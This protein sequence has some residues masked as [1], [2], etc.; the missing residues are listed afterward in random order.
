MAYRY[1]KL[2]TI[3]G[4][5]SWG[6]NLNPI[7]QRILDKVHAPEAR[8]NLAKCHEQKTMYT[9]DHRSDGDTWDGVCN[10]AIAHNFWLV[11]ELKARIMEHYIHA[12]R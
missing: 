4:E 1:M 6:L 3:H 7:V 10:P 2:K 12:R 8:L 11:A 9:L 5:W